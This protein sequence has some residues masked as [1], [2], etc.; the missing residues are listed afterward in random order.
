MPAQ[1]PAI[2]RSSVLG[3]NARSDMR[4]HRTARSTTTWP[5]P[6]SA[7]STRTRS[8]VSISSLSTLR[9]SPPMPFGSSISPTSTVRVDPHRGVGGTRT[10]RSP[11]STRAST[12][13]SPAGS[14]RR[15]RSRSSEPIPSLVV[16][17]QLL[18]V[19]DD[20]GALA[21]PVPEVD[22][23][24]RHE[25]RDREHG[26]VTSVTSAIASHLKNPRTRCESRAAS[27]FAS[28]AR[29][30]DGRV[31]GLAREPE[32]Q[33]AGEQEEPPGV[34][35]GPQRRPR[36]Q[37]RARDG[38]EPEP[39]QRPRPVAPVAERRGGDRVLLALVGDDERGG[40]VDEDAGPAQEGEDDEPDAEDGGVDLEVAGQAPADAREHAVG[41]AALEPAEI[42]V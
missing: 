21:D 18:D 38:E 5:A 33:D 6:T 23:E 40:E 28:G 15:L 4:R 2:T 11:T 7:S 9:P 12:C 24:D 35:V 25:G 26:S 17:L 1:T 31:A 16:V 37:D 36:E 41:A 3:A 29:P 14:C 42:W 8:P 27:A 30:L 19:R 20:V 13:V 39:D 10:F 34:A 22:V 32:D